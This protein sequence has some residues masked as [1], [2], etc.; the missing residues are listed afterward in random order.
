MSTI[1]EDLQ[2]CVIEA[3]NRRQLARGLNEVARTLDQRRAVLCILSKACDEDN[4]SRLIKAMCAEHGIPMMQVD[5][6]AVLGTWAGL[7]KYSEDGEVR[8]I[9]KT[10]CVVIQQWGPGESRAQQSVLDYIRANEV[11]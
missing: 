11:K 2:Q 1:F 3:R 6:S 7:V 8:K 10:A 5:D 9:V 4:Y